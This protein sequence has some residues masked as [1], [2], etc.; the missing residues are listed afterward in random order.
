MVR[1]QH[2]CLK[3]LYLLLRSRANF[4][5]S[6]NLRMHIS[7]CLLRSRSQER[8]SGLWVKNLGDLFPEL[9]HFGTRI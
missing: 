5:L 3:I 1:G 4:D 7:W 2:W 6:E 9:K 8:L